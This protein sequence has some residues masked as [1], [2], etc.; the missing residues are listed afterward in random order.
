MCGRFALSISSVVIAKLFELD[1]VPDIQPRFNIAPSQPIAAIL[2]QGRQ[3]AKRILKQLQWGLVPFWAKDP[4]IGSRMINARSETVAEKPAFRHAFARQR[5]LIPASGFYEWQKVKGGKQP[6]FVR[7]QDE[8]CFAMAGLWDRWQGKEKIIESCNILTTDANE[9]MKPIHNRMP[10][11][12]KPEDYALWLDPE[13][14]EK[15]QLLELLRPFSPNAMVAFAVSRRVN[16]PTH[17]APD[18]IDPL[19]EKKGGENQLFES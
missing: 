12:L 13:K 3:E 17:D 16:H 8:D 15:E 7:L 5:C 10:V 11:I 6:F 9:L 4:S 1:E 19:P 2:R 14:T 18:C